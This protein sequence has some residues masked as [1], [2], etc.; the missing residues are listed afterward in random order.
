MN[1]AVALHPNSSITVTEYVPSWETV[2]TCRVSPLLQ[3]KNNVGVPPLTSAERKTSPTPSVC[4]IETKNGVG[5]AVANAAALVLPTLS[6][7]VTL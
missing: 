5:T 7:A 1:A 6:V 3:I 2:V 4:E